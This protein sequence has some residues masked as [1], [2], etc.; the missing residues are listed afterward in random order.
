M[1]CG[2]RGGRHSNGPRGNVQNEGDALT[3]HVVEIGD[4]EEGSLRRAEGRC[5]GARCRCTMAR[6]NSTQLGPSLTNSDDVPEDVLPT[7]CGVLLN[8]LGHHGRWG[9]RED[10]REIYQLIHHHGC[11]S[12]AI[13][14]QL[15]LR[16][17]GSRHILVLR[18][19]EKC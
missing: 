17:E 9:N 5:K 14:T 3:G 10:G 8:S 12:R 15:L 4:H 11:R 16:G 18:F 1:I 13:D 6:A 19:H 7:L 2:K